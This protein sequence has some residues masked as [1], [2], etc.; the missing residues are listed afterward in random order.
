[1]AW[2]LAGHSDFAVPAV[3]AIACQSG[4]GNLRRPMRHARQD[5]AG[6]HVDLDNMFN[7]VMLAAVA[8]AGDHGAD[9]LPISVSQSWNGGAVRN[10]SRPRPRRRANGNAPPP[11]IPPGDFAGCAACAGARQAPRPPCRSAAWI[12]SSSFDVTPGVDHAELAAGLDRAGAIAV[13]GLSR[14][15][16][17]PARRRTTWPA[18][19]PT[20]STPSS[21]CSRSPFAGP[22][23]TPANLVGLLERP[24]SPRA[25]ADQRPR[26]DGLRIGEFR[27]PPGQLGADSLGPDHQ[28]ERAAAAV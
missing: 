16:W 2:F 19:S 14:A 22:R 21:R 12:R 9:R 28:G 10:T 7:K 1:M 27:R 18:R 8:L 26:P 15:P 20:T 3:A 17:S 4:L 6:R 5:A 23:A 24:L 25:A 13:A 11:Q